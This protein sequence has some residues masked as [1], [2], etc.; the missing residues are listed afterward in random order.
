MK[1]MST[2][3]VSDLECARGC[4]CPARGGQSD[5]IVKLWQMC[6]L[7]SVGKLLRGCV[8]DLHLDEPRKE[9]VDAH[10]CVTLQAWVQATQSSAF[11]SCFTGNK[12]YR[13]TARFFTGWIN[14]HFGTNFIFSYIDLLG[15]W[16]M[17]CVRT[18]TCRGQR[19]DR[20][21]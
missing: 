11:I 5:T 7:R 14:H 16:F 17:C 9:L 20:G 13:G 3:F 19:T 15:F 10:V 18:W 2:Y 6:S 4:G 12:L 1:N 21:N 8:H